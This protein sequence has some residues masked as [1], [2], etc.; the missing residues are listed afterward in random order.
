MT[1]RQKKIYPN[2]KW[3]GK[4]FFVS[5]PVDDG[6]SVIEAKWQPG[7]TYIIQVRE[8]GSDEWSLGFETP[9]TSCS[10]SGLKPDTEY[11]AQLRAKNSAGVGEPAYA[12]ARTTPQGDITDGFQFPPST[13][14]H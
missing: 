10:F 9:L 11:E 4:E 1:K 2:V 8:V 5:L 14:I 7:I 13:M 3:D 12:K 6:K